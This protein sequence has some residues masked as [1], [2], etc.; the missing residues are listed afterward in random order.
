M[1]SLSYV[2]TNGTP[3][4]RYNFSKN[5]L[6]TVVRKSDLIEFGMTESWITTPFNE[7]IRVVKCLSEYD[8]W[9]YQ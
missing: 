4:P 8:L 1:G 2:T 7:K 5:M 3:N 6:S 9:I